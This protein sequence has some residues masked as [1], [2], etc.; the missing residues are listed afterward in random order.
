VSRSLNGIGS[1]DCRCD[2]ADS[3]KC[4]SRYGTFLYASFVPMSPRVASADR[5]TR[6]TCSASTFIFN[7]ASL[8]RNCKISTVVVPLVKTAPRPGSVIWSS[9]LSLS[10]WS[11][12]SETPHGAARRSGSARVPVLRRY[13]L[14]SGGYRNSCFHRRTWLNVASKFDLQKA[15]P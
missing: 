5:G 6:K 9:F 3:S 4:L 12:P 10:S 7:L 2:K 1:Q 11:A 13:S 8:A 15:C 14:H